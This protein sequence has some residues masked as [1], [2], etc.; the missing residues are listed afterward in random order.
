MLLLVLGQ[1]FEQAVGKKKH[2]VCLSSVHA[3]LTSDNANATVRKYIL[4]PSAARY[5]PTDKKYVHVCIHQWMDECLFALMHVCVG[6]CRWQRSLCLF[7]QQDF[8]SRNKIY[9]EKATYN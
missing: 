4:C 6:L 2:T 5:R 8:Y 3:H 1:N 9:N 7:W